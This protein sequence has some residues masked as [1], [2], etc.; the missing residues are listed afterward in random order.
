MVESPGS[1]QRGNVE[2]L[3]IVNL[4]VVVLA[5]LTLRAWSV[6]GHFPGW[7]YPGGLAVVIA[8]GLLTCKRLRWARTLLVVV[9]GI[10]SATVVVAALSGFYYSPMVA[11]VLL[12][13]AGLLAGAAW[14][15]QT[16]VHIRAFLQ[17]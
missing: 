7:T 14:R 8:L 3:I 15:L 2:V 6:S 5:S 16:S 11:V 1:V 17:A 9:A 12:M 4:C 10:A 13:V